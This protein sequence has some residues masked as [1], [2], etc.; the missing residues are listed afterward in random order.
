M[1]RL[2][3]CF[4]LL[5]MAA[6]PLAAQHSGPPASPAATESVTV[7][8]KILTIKYSA[9]SVKGRAGHI[10]TKDGLISKDPTYPLWRAGANGA[11]TLHTD[12]AL[13]LGELMLA[14]GDYSLYVDISNPDAWV[15]VVNKQVGQ[16]G[17]VYDKA[18]EVGRVKFAMTKP[19]KTIETLGYKFELAGNSGTL[20]LC[21]E[22]HIASVPVMVH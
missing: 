12:A 20:K 16:W 2:L 14:A 4:S 7:N 3:A 5:L 9:P 6:L 1:K 22:D 11:T 13:M 10:F 8:G 19:E 21:W 18:Q 15:L 17:T